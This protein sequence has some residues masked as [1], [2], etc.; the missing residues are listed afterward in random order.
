MENTSNLAWLYAFLQPFEQAY[1]V[2]HEQRPQGGALKRYSHRSFILFFISVFLQR[3]FA[4]KTMAT[5]AHRHYRRYYFP[6]APS[7]KTIRRRFRQLP[8][9]IIYLMPAIAKHC[10]SSLCHRIFNLKWFFSDKS[11]FRAKGGL[12]HKKHREA[13]I[14]PHPSIDTDASWAKSPYHGWR[15]GYGLLIFT[16]EARFPTACFADTASFNEV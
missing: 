11:I 1:T 8:K 16:N 3:K 6:Q 10:M 15:Y 2:K 12:W 13:G 9:V 4:F 14:L 5:Y 7:R